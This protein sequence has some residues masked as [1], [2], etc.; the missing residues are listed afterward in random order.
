MFGKLSSSVK[1][2][3]SSSWTP[4]VSNRPVVIAACWR[5]ARLPARWLCR[6]DRVGES[7]VRQ[8]V[9]RQMADGADAAH[10]GNGRKPLA[11]ASIGG[12]NRFGGLVAA[13]GKREAEREVAIGAEPRIDALHL[14]ERAD[15][16]AAPT[17]STTLKAICTTSSVARVR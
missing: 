12:D 7:P 13:S 15:Q 1:N 17:S 16:Q 4:S 2:R 14:D 5:E 9:E 6:V 3:P 8:I 11:E 10:T